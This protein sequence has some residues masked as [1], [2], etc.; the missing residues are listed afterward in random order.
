VADPDQQRARLGQLIEQRRKTLG[1]SLSAAARAAG[2]NRATWV[3]TERVTRRTAEYNYVAIERVLGWAAGSVDAILAGSEPAAVQGRVGPLSPRV[4]ADV[5]MVSRLD[6]PAA[7]RLAMIRSVVA[8]HE[9]MLAEQQQ[10]PGETS[11]AAR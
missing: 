10:A 5:E 7:D 8:L 1:L 2:I 3:G 11:I 6:M 9:E 4:V